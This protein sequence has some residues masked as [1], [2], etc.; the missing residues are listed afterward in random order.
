MN[1]AASSVAQAAVA[2]LDAALRGDG[3]C[4]EVPLQGCRGDSLQIPEAAKPYAQAPMQVRGP[5]L[6]TH[7][8]PSHQRCTKSKFLQLGEAGI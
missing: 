6:G 3:I 4:V 1:A 8:D 2:Y 5:P 7:P